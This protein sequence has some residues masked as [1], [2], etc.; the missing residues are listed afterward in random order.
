MNITELKNKFHNNKPFEHLVIDNLFNP[1]VLD[2]LLEDFNTNQKWDVRNDDKIQVKTRSDWKE[3]S[4][5]PTNSLNFINTINSTNFMF[6]LSEIAGEKGLLP[7]PYIRAGGLNN[8]FNDNVLAQHID[9]NKA[10]E[11]GL[12]RYLNVIIYLNKDWKPEYGGQLVLGDGDNKIEIEPIFNRT[13]IF[14]T[15]DKSLH[16]VRRITCPENMS[17]KSLILY[18]YT[19][20]NKFNSDKINDRHSAIFGKEV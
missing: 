8:M 19:V 7:D 16:G 20:E 10:D 14:K 5:I 11:L 13:V 9:G 1:F 3:L 12:Y 6:M 18:Y 4:D 17:R 2:E 15:N